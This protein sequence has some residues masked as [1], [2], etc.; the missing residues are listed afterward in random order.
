VLR[1]PGGRNTSGIRLLRGWENSM[2][3]VSADLQAAG[4]VW[5]LA[6]YGER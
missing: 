4:A 6:S 2:L 3:L 5:R 1:V